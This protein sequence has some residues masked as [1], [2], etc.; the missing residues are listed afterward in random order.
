DAAAE[1]HQM[2]PEE[3]LLSF[4]DGRREILDRGRGHAESEM[5]KPE[6]NR[7]KPGHPAGFIEAFANLYADFSELL[8]GQPESKD[9]VHSAHAA[10]RGL[11]FLEE[12]HRSPIRKSR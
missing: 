10:A 3:L 7:F 12:V 8:V 11:R 2:N 5:E 6:Y 1:W 4:N 9:H